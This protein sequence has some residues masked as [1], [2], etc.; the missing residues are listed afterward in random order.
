MLERGLLISTAC[1][2]LTG[3]KDP[4]MRANLSILGDTQFPYVMML[5]QRVTEGLLRARLA[6]LGGTVECGWTL[7]QLTKPTSPGGKVT[8]EF[9][10]G[11]L[12]ERNTVQADFVIGADG[13]HSTVRQLSGL[14]W[15]RQ[16]YVSLSP[17]HTC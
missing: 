17:R 8:L 13:G 14:A 12:A 1:I 2:R 11:K 4:L 5:Q 9:E 10:H 7:K 6:D 15:P 16:S 3:R